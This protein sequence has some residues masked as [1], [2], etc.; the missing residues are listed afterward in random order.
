MFACRYPLPRR[1]TTYSIFMRQE[2]KIYGVLQQWLCRFRHVDAKNCDADFSEVAASRKRRKRKS[3]QVIKF[4]CDG[5][6]V[7]VL[8]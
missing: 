8:N 5:P 2:G 6:Y 3:G 7:L 4:T 1:Y